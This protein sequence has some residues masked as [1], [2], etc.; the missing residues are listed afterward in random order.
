MNGILPAAAVGIALTF[1]RLAVAAVLLGRN[2]DVSQRAHTVDRM[3]LAAFHGTMNA[4]VVLVRHARTPPVDLS[5][6]ERR[7]LQHTRIFACDSGKN[8]LCC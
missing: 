8:V 1:I 2:L 7:I 3:M 6:F 5:P 4:L